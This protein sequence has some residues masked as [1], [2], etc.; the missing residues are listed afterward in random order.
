MEFAQVELNWN[1]TLPGITL[2]SCK[3][4]NNLPAGKT[5][6]GL[7]YSTFHRHSSKLHLIETLLEGCSRGRIRRFLRSGLFLFFGEHAYKRF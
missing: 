7:A 5:F 2:S 4:G 3:D 6:P 1:L